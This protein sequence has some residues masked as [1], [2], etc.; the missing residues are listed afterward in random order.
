MNRVGQVLPWGDG[1]GI[2]PYGA[3]KRWEF[4]TVEKPGFF[5]EIPPEMEMK[6]SAQSSLGRPEVKGDEASARAK[7]AVRF[8]EY[9]LEHRRIR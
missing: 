1:D 5:Q 2:E 4:A 8:M 7:N 6:D 9:L 3:K